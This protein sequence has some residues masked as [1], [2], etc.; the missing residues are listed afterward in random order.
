MITQS[1]EKFND[2]MTRRS[3]YKDGARVA[4][5]RFGDTLRSTRSTSGIQQQTKEILFSEAILTQARRDG[6]TQ[7][8]VIISD[9]FQRETVYRVALAEM[10]A[11][12]TLRET[13][14]EEPTLQRGGNHRTAPAYAIPGAPAPTPSHK[15]SDDA[16]AAMLRKVA[17]RLRQMAAPHESA[18]DLVAPTSEEYDR[19]RGADMPSSATLRAAYRI[20][21]RDVCAA[22]GLRIRRGNGIAPDLT[23]L[24]AAPAIPDVRIV[25]DDAPAA[26]LTGNVSSEPPPPAIPPARSLAEIEADPCLPRPQRDP[27]TGQ[28]IPP[29]DADG[30]CAARRSRRALCA[31]RTAHRRRFVIVSVAASRART[32]AAH[33]SPRQTCARLR[34]CRMMRPRL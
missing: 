18:G 14:A 1:Y 31:T 29:R 33:L 10:L 24:D 13:P 2:C 27:I 15:A 32:A 30:R 34:I 23:G 28:L 8:E 6:I 17:A 25:M 19:R 16:R 11:R 22:A 12:G 26:D 3:V 5:V 7:L 4:G 9:R 20:Q 21:W